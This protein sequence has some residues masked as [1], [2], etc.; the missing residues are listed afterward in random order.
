MTRDER[1]P[2]RACAGD[3]EPYA[4]IGLTREQAARALILTTCIFVAL[5]VVLIAAVRA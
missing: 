1:Y 2:E 5:V 3:D 4:E